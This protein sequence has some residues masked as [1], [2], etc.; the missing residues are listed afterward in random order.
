MSQSLHIMKV[1]SVTQNKHCHEPENNGF[2]F[3]IT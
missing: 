3:Y 2:L 1:L